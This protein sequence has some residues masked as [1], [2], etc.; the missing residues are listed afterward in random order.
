MKKTLIAP[1]LRETRWGLVYLAVQLLALPTLLTLVMQKLPFPV[2]E[3]GLNITFFVLNFLCTG[4]I[5]FSYLKSSLKQL[6]EN[7]PAC[8]TTA[9]LGFA[10]YQVLAA[11]MGHLIGQLY[12]DFLNV[13]DMTLLAMLRQQ[14]WPMA[15][16]TVILVPITEEALY[17][18]LLF[19]AFHWKSPVLAYGMS[20]VLFS[21]IHVM[22]YVG[23]YPAGL[24]VL[25]FLQYLPAGLV[26]A[27]T[28]AR[29]GTVFTP[30]LIHMAVTALGIF[31]MR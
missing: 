19:G 3:V 30:I 1:S 5:L 28:Y 25:C 17:R 24:L 15:L 11:L 2:S 23:L 13:N 29:T 12:P 7:L 31:L 18:G 27:W 6:A 20:V 4:A 26:L 14:F 8:L 10:V 21:L 22:G 16:C 9:L